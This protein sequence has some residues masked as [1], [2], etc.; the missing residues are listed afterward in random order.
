MLK[1]SGLPV[2]SWPPCADVPGSVVTHL[3]FIYIYISMGSAVRHIVFVYLCFRE[4][5]AVIGPLTTSFPH[6]V[7]SGISHF[8]TSN[9]LFHS[10]YHYT[11]TLIPKHNY[12]SNM[13]NNIEERRVEEV[14]RYEHLYN[15]STSTYK[16]AQMTANSWREIAPSTVLAVNCLQHPQP[17]ENHK[18]KRVRRIRPSARNGVRVAYFSLKG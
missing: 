8:R 11:A 10:L 1:V 3:V 5:F 17:S 9:F 7:I 13:D 2:E 18:R 12:D 16:D 6:N 15:P 14:R 4:P